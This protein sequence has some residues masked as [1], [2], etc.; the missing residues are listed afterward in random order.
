MAWASKGG[1]QLKLDLN[2]PTYFCAHE[3]HMGTS[4]RCSFQRSADIHA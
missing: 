2:I 1:S 3:L 4:G